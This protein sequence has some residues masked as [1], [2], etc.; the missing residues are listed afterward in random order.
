[1]AVAGEML[2]ILDKETVRQTL[3]R[4]AKPFIKRSDSKSLIATVAIRLYCENGG[5]RLSLIEFN[6]ERA[7]ELISQHYDTI[8]SRVVAELDK[9]V[10][11]R[12]ELHGNVMLLELHP[13]VSISQIRGILQGVNVGEILLEDNIVESCVAT[14]TFLTVY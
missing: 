5:H 3:N 7:R 9:F 4:L 1:M 2:L 13:N 12:S 8:R 11:K 6:E 10:V 14:A